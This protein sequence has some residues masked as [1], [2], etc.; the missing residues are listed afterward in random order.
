[1]IEAAGIDDKLVGEG[2]GESCAP[3][4]FRLGGGMEAV[5]GGGMGM[6]GVASDI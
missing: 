5:E 3:E 4:V 1:M 6:S 2:M